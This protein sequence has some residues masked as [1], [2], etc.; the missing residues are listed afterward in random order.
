MQE[1][2]TGQPIVKLTCDSIYSFKNRQFICKNF[3]DAP[4]CVVRHQ[5]VMLTCVAAYA[6]RSKGYDLSGLRLQF[7]READQDHPWREV[8][9][10]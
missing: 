7:R 5:C 4:Y 6:H 8:W 1:M 3:D 2:D 9:R 10:R